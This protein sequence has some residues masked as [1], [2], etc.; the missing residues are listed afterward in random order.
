YLFDVSLIKQLIQL[1]Q[2]HGETLFKSHGDGLLEIRKC[3][4]RDGYDYICTLVICKKTILPNT[5]REVRIYRTVFVAKTIF[6]G[7]RPFLNDGNVSCLTP[8]RLPLRS[9]HCI[10]PKSTF[11]ELH[12][13]RSRLPRF[14]GPP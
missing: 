8:M 4:K 3:L 11:S 6:C 14:G 5:L 9:F 1:S 2:P 12:G 10:Q 7:K 13:F